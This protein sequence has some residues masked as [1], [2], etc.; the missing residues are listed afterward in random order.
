MQHLWGLLLLSLPIFVNDTKA[1]ELSILGAAFI[2][3]ADFLE[4]S[5]APEFAA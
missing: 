1:D 3:L 4:A 5:G 2:G